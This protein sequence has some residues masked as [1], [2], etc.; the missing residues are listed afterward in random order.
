MTIFTSRSRKQNYKAEN[1]E[2]AAGEGIHVGSFALV[3]NFFQNSSLLKNVLCLEVSG[4]GPGVAVMM[5]L[6]Y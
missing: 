1:Q 2:G 4:Y 6:V 5:V 3:L